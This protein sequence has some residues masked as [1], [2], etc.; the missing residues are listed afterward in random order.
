[1]NSAPEGSEIEPLNP[2]EMVLSLKPSFVARTCSAD[3]DH[4]TEI[5]RKAL[6]HKGFAFI[7]ILQ[8]CPTYNKVTSNEW[9]LDRI[10]PIEELK[11]YDVHNIWDARKIS[12]EMDILYVGVLYHNPNRESFLE[13]T[14]RDGIKTT[15]VEEVRHY[16]ISEF[17]KEL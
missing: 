11:D 15:L 5:F 4:M 10:R 2:L 16:D 17:L 13:C 7:E 6:N 12:E 9:Y 1:M 14:H 3:T 8:T